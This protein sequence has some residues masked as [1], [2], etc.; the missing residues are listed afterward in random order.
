MKEVKH[1]YYILGESI[2]IKF[3]NIQN[4]NDRK[5]TNG[6]LGLA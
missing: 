3:Y 4:Y 6:C 1:K 2:Y 5:Q